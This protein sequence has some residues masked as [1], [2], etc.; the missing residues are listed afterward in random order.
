M[1]V[2]LNSMTVYS[3]YV[4]KQSIGGFICEL[5]HIGDEVQI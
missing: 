3:M 1:L 4:G 2:F 5:G